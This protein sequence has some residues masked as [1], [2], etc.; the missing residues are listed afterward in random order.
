MKPR[1][2]YSSPERDPNP[3]TQL[4]PFPAQSYWVYTALTHGDQGP[5][6]KSPGPDAAASGGREQ[7]LRRAAPRVRL[8]DA[9]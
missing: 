1:R 5:V 3:T 2:W 8:I 7:G 9:A 6:I 4:R